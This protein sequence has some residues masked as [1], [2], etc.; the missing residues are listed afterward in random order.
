[1]V[2]ARSTRHASDLAKG[3]DV[4]IIHV[5]ADDPEACVAAVRLAMAYQEKFREDVLIDLVGY[6][7][8]G[9]NEGDEPTY[10]QPQMYERIRALPTVRERY[11]ATLAERGVVSAEAAK[12][13]A[14]A[15]YQRLVEVQQKFKAGM[16]KAVP[17]EP[18]PAERSSGM[19]VETAV[20]GGAAQ[21][22]QRAAADL[23]SGLHGKSQAQEAA[24]AAPL[25]AGSR[26]R[27]RLGPRRGSGACP[28]CWS[29]GFR[30]G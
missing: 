17:A 14:E 2:D 6:R 19:E 4:P 15:A 22:D 16:G 5:N 28:R 25:G 24:G 3:F 9:H 27:H 30:S 13:E 21:R 20:A 10:T 7:R 23:A 18:I 8:H 26:G 12:S 11:A 1:M 29:R